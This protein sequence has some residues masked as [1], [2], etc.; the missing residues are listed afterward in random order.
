MSEWWGYVASLVKSL[1]VLIMYFNQKGVKITFSIVDIYINQFNIVKYYVK[2]P[3][4]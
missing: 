3:R 1:N 4:I 2:A